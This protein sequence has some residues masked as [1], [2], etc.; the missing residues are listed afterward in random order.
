MPHEISKKNFAKPPILV[1]FINRKR[2]LLYQG[3]CSVQVCGSPRVSQYVKAKRSWLVYSRWINIAA[4]SANQK[5]PVFCGRYRLAGPNILRNLI[6][7]GAA[8][9]DDCVDFWKTSC[10]YT[11]KEFC[12]YLTERRRRRWRVAY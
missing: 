1:F 12:S 4:S 7:N 9:V 3:R 6:C 8:E 5:H 10:K 2:L 11:S